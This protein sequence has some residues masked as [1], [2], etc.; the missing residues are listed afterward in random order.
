M[1]IPDL[2]EVACAGK[3]NVTKR[4]KHKTVVLIDETGQSE[5]GLVFLYTGNEI[6]TAHVT[7]RQPV[8]TPIQVA[9]YLKDRGI[10][11]TVLSIASVCGWLREGLLRGFRVPGRGQGG[12][13]RVPLGNLDGFVPPSRRGRE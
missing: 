8:L 2:R 7:A 3:G 10:T 13:W 9:Q 6:V 4:R 1:K 12:Q 5:D 11:E